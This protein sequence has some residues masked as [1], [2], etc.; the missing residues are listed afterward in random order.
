MKKLFRCLIAAAAA[1]GS[2][3]VISGTAAAASPQSSIAPGFS[4]QSM[5]ATS[6]NLTLSAQLGSPVSGKKVTFF[7]QTHEFSNKGWMVVGS[8]VTNS[9]GVATYVYTPTWTGATKFGAAQG[10]DTSVTAPTV[11]KSFQVLRDPA[12]VPQSV[13]EYARPLGSV[14]GVFVKSLLSIVAIVWI[15]L[16]GSLAIIIWRMP[17]LAGSTSCETN[18]KWSH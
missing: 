7:V 12:G 1:I 16:L 3:L 6:D 13:I 14:G 8:G 11:V 5:S 17:R 15:V 18:S 10:L 2:V 4:V 9:L